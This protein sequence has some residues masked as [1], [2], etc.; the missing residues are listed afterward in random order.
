MHL[1][2]APRGI[3]QIDEA[4]IVYRDFEGRGEKFN[5]EGDR[6]Y[7]IFKNILTKGA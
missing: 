6:K 1:T 3:I 5:R 4:K 7:E 2:W